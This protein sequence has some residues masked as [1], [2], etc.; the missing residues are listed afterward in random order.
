MS[1]CHC[2]TYAGTGMLNICCVC[3]VGVI[4][5]VL[6]AGK[7]STLITVESLL[8]KFMTI[9]YVGCFKGFL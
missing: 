1:F 8:R 6:C 9:R 3:A 7:V 4:V 5:C 2:V